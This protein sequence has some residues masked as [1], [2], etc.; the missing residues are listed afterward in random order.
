MQF[1]NWESTMLDSRQQPGEADILHVGLRAKLQTRE[2][3]T[4]ASF[5]R[6]TQRTSKK[7]ANFQSVI[8]YLK[9]PVAG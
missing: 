9:R 2:A 7:V 4:H 6:A 5:H 8:V 1:V 3:Q